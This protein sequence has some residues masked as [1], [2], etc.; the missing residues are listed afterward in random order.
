MGTISF[1]CREDS[2]DDICA[3]ERLFG[4]RRKA[5]MVVGIGDGIDPRGRRSYVMWALG[6]VVGH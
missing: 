1:Y 5:A 3:S 6:W 4:L 2:G